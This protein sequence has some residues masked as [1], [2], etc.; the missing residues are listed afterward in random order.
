M[1]ARDKQE[2][3]SGSQFNLL[4]AVNLHWVKTG[5]AILFDTYKKAILNG[6]Q[7]DDAIINFAQKLQCT[8]KAI[9]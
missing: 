1:I 4:A 6:S 3:C 2:N 7:L 8:S 5:H 9:P